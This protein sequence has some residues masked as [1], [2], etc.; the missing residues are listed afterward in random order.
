MAVQNHEFRL[1][2]KT[3][4]AVE[5]IGWPN[6]IMW[7]YSHVEVAVQNTGWWNI[8]GWPLEQIATDFSID[9]TNDITTDTTYDIRTHVTSDI[10]T[11]ISTDITNYITT[12]LHLICQLIL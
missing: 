5:H 10:I 3:L 7:S 8:N 9:M 4:V 12:I 2:L 6:D 11:H 1:L